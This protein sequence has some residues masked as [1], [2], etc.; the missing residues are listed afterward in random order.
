VSEETV[1]DTDEK[2]DPM[3]ELIFDTTD[4]VEKL[5]STYKDW[6]VLK[7]TVKPYPLQI[8]RDGRRILLESNVLTWAVQ[9]QPQPP[10]SLKKDDNRGE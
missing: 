1:M 6:V 8:M 9:K 3:F 4:L 2:I 7:H 10:L 5:K